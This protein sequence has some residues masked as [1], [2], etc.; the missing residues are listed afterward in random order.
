MAAARMAVA[1]PGDVAPVSPVRLMPTQGRPSSLQHTRRWVWAGERE[2][3]SEELL[4]SR[5]PPLQVLREAARQARPKR[6]L[7][8]CS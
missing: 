3:P 8:I 7:E 4:R 5:E 1:C 2:K 6:T